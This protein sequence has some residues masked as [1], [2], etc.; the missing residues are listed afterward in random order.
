MK[1]RIE[2]NPRTDEKLSRTSDAHREPTFE[3]PVRKWNEQSGVQLRR[4]SLAVTD[5]EQNG[6]EKTLKR[7][8]R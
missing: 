8:S 6:D 4:D 7:G 3:I 1:E 2:E 5:L